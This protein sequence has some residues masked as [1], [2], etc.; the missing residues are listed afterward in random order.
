MFVPAVAVDNEDFR[1]AVAAHLVGGGLEKFHLHVGAV[2]NGARFVTSLS[3]LAEI[4]SGEDDGILLKRGVFGG[5]PDIEEIGAERKVRAMFFEN[6][7]GEQASSLRSSDSFTK[8]SG[9]QFL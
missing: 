1:A 2:G 7:E 6:A 4:I 8:F 3:D 9:G 5:V